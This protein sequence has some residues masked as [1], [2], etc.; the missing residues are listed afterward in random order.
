MTNKYWF[1]PKRYGYGVVPSSLEGWLVTLI[2]ILITIYAAIKIE[3]NSFHFMVI[4]I[5]GI[6]IFTLIAKNKTEGEW[7]W[8]WG[9]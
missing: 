7:K 2:F 5:I 3:N 8:R 4:L 6:I 9:K 1:K